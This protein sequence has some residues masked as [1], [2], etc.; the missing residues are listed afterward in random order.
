M[1]IDTSGQY[2]RSLGPKYYKPDTEITLKYSLFR[3]HISENTLN[4]T[5]RAILPCSLTSFWP[6]RTC[7]MTGFRHFGMSGQYWPLNGTQMASNMLN[8]IYLLIYD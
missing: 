2:A 7:K 5:R 3:V 1:D 4:R 8:S 6:F